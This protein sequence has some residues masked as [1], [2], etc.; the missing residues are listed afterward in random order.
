[1]PNKTPK[2]LVLVINSIAVTM[3]GTWVKFEKVGGSETPSSS[4]VWTQKI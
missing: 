3:G 4:R 2:D 1:M